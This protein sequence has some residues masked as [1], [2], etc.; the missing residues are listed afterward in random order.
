MSFAIFIKNHI[1]QSTNVYHRSQSLMRG[2]E[3]LIVRCGSFDLF[4]VAWNTETRLFGLRNLLIIPK[5][6]DKLTCQ[7][8]Y[9][10]H[11]THQMKAYPFR[12]ITWTHRK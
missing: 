7:Q 6:S 10:E 1:E 9:T 2:T 8:N 3:G 4:R 5:E 12:N 11:Q